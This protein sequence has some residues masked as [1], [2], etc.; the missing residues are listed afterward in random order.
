MRTIWNGTLAVGRLGIPVGLAVA[1]KRADVAFRTL[2]EPCGTPVTQRQRC[3]SCDEDVEPGQTVRGWEAAPGQFL[4]VDDAELAALAPETDRTIRV[5]HVVPIHQVDVVYRDRG[6]WLTPAPDRVNRRPYWLLAQALADEQAAAIARFTLWGRENL[7]LVR[8]DTDGP[9]L[10][11]DTLYQA[12]D[13]RQPVETREL[14][15]QHHEID[16]GDLRLTRRLVRAMRTRFQPDSQLTGQY[17][18]NVQ[19]LLE[20]K[21][22]GRAWAPSDRPAPVAPVVDLERALRESLQ[23]A[24]ARR[25]PATHR[26]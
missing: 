19:A 15:R 10:A 1:Q 8:A 4:V 21:I 12:D 24:N 20:A 25:R 23:D 26:R 14:A 6:Y 22:D 3:P 11:L 5:E 18:E 16:P 13:V 7:A 2:H 9:V 17:R